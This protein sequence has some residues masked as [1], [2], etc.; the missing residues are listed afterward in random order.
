MK[1]K[2]EQRPESVA[3]GAMDKFLVF[4]RIYGPHEHIRLYAINPGERW[5]RGRF[6]FSP[7]KT[8]SLIYEKQDPD[9]F[10]VEECDLRS[11][12]IWTWISDFM[13]VGMDR[14]QE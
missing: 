13:Q 14:K 12:S 10:Y 2:T 3:T 11:M 5:H 1:K 9:H 6:E 8:A 4:E 7:T